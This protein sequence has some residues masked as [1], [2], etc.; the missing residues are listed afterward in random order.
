MYK[1]H[2]DRSKFSLTAGIHN[3][4]DHSPRHVYK[5]HSAVPL[6]QEDQGKNKE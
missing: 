6:V 3:K 4:E 5:E 1:H 2:P